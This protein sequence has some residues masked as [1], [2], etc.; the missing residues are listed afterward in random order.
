M[1]L[2]IETVQVEKP[3]ESE[4]SIRRTL[5]AAQKG[6]GAELQKALEQ[7]GLIKAHC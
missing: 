2:F 5:P 3:V 6:D 7:E 1:K 4:I